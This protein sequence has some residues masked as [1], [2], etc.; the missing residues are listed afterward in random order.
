[1]AGVVEVCLVAKDRE[2]TADIKNQTLET[3]LWR[4]D[5][6]RI[7]NTLKCAQKVN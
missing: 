2:W 4:L 5:T 6:I 1:M 7:G 3:G